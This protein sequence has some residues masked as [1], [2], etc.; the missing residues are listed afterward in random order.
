MQRSVMICIQGDRIKEGMILVR[1]MAQLEEKG[2]LFGKT[3]GQT[4]S[5]K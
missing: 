5:K 3:E 4:I 2:A 1:H